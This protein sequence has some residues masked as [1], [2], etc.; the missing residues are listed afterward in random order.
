MNTI[1]I[2]Q[3]LKP[4]R[5]SIHAP[6]IGVY[7]RDCLP[8]RPPKRFSLVM[9]TATSKESGDHWTLLHSNG[10]TLYFFCSFG[11]KPMQEVLD[12]AI[13]AKL[14][15]IIYSK[16][17]IQSDDSIVCGGYTIYIAIQLAKAYS[18]LSIM[19]H[20]AKISQDDKFIEKY[21]LSKFNFK[22]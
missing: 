9:N 7:A 2:E 12:F 15:R 11:N 17:K 22:I 8:R 13:R 1:E 6:F 16:V 18:F 20:F 5:K 4:Y 14:K 21:L 10:K 19:R 3:I